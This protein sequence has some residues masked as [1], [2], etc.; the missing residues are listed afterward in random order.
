MGSP[1]ETSVRFAMRERF[2]PDGGLRLVLSGE[3]DLSVVQALADRLTRLRN[4]GYVVRVD[5]S[6]L[7]FIDS[8]GLRELIVA[9][10]ARRHAGRVEVDHRVSEP[11]RRTID[12]A[13]VRSH[14]WPDLG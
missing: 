6:Q 3:L 7:E 12:L 9:L 1:L 2:E 11:V 4:E 13:G 5:L 10:Q 8:S 14:F